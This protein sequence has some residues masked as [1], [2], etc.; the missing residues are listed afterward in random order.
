MHGPTDQ[1]DPAET[2]DEIRRFESA[3]AA[4]AQELDA[5]IDHTVAQLGQ[6]ND[7]AILQTHRQ[8]L[9]DPTLADKVKL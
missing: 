1:L 6:Q 9:A 3:C 4:A 8:M 2:P 7:T 5:R